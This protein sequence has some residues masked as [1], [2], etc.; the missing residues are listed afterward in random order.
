[1]IYGGRY[2]P[3]QKGNV[4]MSDVTGIRVLVS[5]GTSGLGYAMSAELLA[6]GARVVLTGRDAE[7]TVAAAAQLANSAPGLALGVA[8][9]VR[10]E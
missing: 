8:M 9:D 6:G 7:R 2:S 3:I 1:M 4:L 5:G 10:D